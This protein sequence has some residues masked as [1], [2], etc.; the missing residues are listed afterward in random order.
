M[1]LAYFITFTTYGTWLHGSAKGSVDAD[2]NKYG[3]PLLAPNAGKKRQS[4]AAMLQPPYTM[5]EAERNIVCRALVDLSGYRKWDLL[6]AH[7]RTNHV[8]LVIR[9]E[10]DP[11]RLMSDLKAGASHCLNVTGFGGAERKRWTRHGSTI[12]LFSEEQI[13]AKIRYTLEEQGER[14]AWYEKPRNG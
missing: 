3:M 9:A 14:M 8:H 4:R 5:Q 1:A 6:A 2:H 11:E 7:V 10:R 12:H 13:L